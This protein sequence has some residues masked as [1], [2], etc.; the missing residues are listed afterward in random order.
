M[1]SIKNTGRIVG[2][3]FLTLMVTYTLGAVVFIQPVLDD[4]DYLVIISANKNRI[5]TGVLLELVNN[6]S[7]LGIAVL[8]F[9]I[10][11]KVNESMA[12]AYA[13]LRIIEFIMQIV[14]DLGPLSLI[15][16]SQEYVRTGASDPTCIEAMGASLIAGRYWAG[17]MVI[18]AYGMGAVIFYYLSHKLRLI[19]RFLSVWGIIGA[20]LVLMSAVLEIFGIEQA[21]Y[22]GVQMGL[23]EII[24]GIWLVIKGFNTPA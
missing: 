12:L 22:L 7:Y 15:T 19:P 20:P 1:Y 2:V 21:S 5:I 3:L 4:P 6:I 8:V 13:G 11:R 23:N 17:E 24:L 16:L 9:P 14:S 10:L 18:I